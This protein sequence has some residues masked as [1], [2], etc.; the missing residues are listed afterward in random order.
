MDGEQRLTCMSSCERVCSGVATFLVLEGGEGK[1]ILSPG[2]SGSLVDKGFERERGMREMSE[3]PRSF[4]GLK[5]QN[6][7]FWGISF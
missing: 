6:A 4:F 1:T 3:T 2:A 5:C 7:V